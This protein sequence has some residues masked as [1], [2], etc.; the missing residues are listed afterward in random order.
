MHEA[1]A[2]SA[3]GS[4]GAVRA[5]V[6]VGVRTG[7]TKRKSDDAEVALGAAGAGAAMVIVYAGGP[8]EGGR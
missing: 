4:A 6:N 2:A 5:G 7:A 8:Y 1:R 3:A